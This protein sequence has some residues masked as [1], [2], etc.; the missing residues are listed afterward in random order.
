MLK[1]ALS[2]DAQNIADEAI[3][4]YAEWVIQLKH[5]LNQLGEIQE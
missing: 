2:D 1:V 3:Q 5:Q 4:I